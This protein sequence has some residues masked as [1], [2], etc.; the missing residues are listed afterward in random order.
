MEHQSVKRGDVSDFHS[1]ALTARR[2][3]FQVKRNQSQPLPTRKRLP[4]PGRTTISP[5]EENSAAKARPKRSVKRRDNE[6]VPVRGGADAIPQTIGE[7]VSRVDLELPQSLPVDFDAQARLARER[8]LAVHNLQF[9]RDKL[10]A[11]E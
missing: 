7:G 2:F 9:V 8:D 10:L 4:I 1:D 3:Y 11:Q 6:R 5:G